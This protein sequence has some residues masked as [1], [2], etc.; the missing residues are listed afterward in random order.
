MGL[1]KTVVLKEAAAPITV[2]GK[3]WGGLRLAFQF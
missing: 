2:N 1:G 3:H